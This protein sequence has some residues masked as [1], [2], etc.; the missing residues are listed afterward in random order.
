MKRRREIKAPTSRLP[1]TRDRGCDALPSTV[2]NWACEGVSARGKATVVDS[3]GCR[4]VRS[5]QG[6]KGT[7]IVQKKTGDNRK[8]GSDTQVKK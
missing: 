1:G 7:G 8:T 3:R 5:S 2:R 4:M 6:P